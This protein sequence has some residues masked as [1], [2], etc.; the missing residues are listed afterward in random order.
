MGK[1]GIKRRKSRLLAVLLAFGL[2]GA[3]HMYAGQHPKGLL[4]I[5]SY[6][7]DLTAIVRLADS[8]GGRHLLMIVYLGI[9]LPVFYFISVFDSLQSMEAEAEE[10][11]AFGLAHGILLALAGFALLLLV[12]PPEAL[13]PWMNELAELSVG[14]FIIIAAVWL[15]LQA[16]KGSV[17][18]FKLGRFTAAALVLMV[19]GLLLWDQIQGR[20][21]ISLLGQWWPV[22]FIMLGFEVIVFSIRFKGAEKKLRLDVTGGAIALV[23]TMTA[24]VVTQYAD[25]PFRWLDQFNVDLNG[26]ADYGEEKGFRY[27]KP[28]MK[29]P[30]EDDVSLIGITNPNGHIT[31]RSGDVQEIEVQTTV[32]VDLPDKTEADK[33]AEQSTVKINPGAEVA[34]DA[35]GKDYGA[36]GSKK[37]RMNMIV[38][39]PMS[40]SDRLHIEETE[41][42]PIESEPPPLEAESPGEDHRLDGLSATE[43]N[44]LSE[45]TEDQ[46]DGELP[47]TPDPGEVEKPA[48]KMSIDADN[49]SVEVAG[50]ALPGGLAI[51]SSSGLVT[52]SGIIGPVTVKGNIGEVRASEIDGDANVE[53]KNGAI[54]AADIE[55]KLYASTL[56]GSLDLKRI[57]DDIEAGTKNG[58]IKIESAG[59]S[60]KADT[61]NGGIELI[62][63]TVGGNWDLDSSVGEI[64]LTMPEDGDYTVYGSVTFGNI[65]TD[66][67]LEASKKTVRGTMGAGT[68]RVQINATNSITIR[69]FGPVQ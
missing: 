11:V 20:N 67:P 46:A 38:T 45:V 17:S 52:V 66:L 9:M 55:G 12:K 5:A 44:E 36:N 60:V 39:V 7:L 19:G 32:W 48:L 25:I 14:P 2:P 43:G 62:S 42:P 21:D 50:L 16:R 31:V 69:R 10:S 40:L 8:D 15:L 65:T 53:M 34:L 56:N 49:G 59:A 68:Y 51:E 41:E 54:A 22:I 6:L 24:Y 30:L 26:A 47:A 23:I 3:G 29:V 28:V 57:R 37:P 63:D 13:L 61:L 1:L 58:K 64:R 35:K 33:V 27:D 18:M 4:L